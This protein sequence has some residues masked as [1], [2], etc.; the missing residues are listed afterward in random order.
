MR[1]VVEHQIVENCNAVGTRIRLGVEREVGCVPVIGNEK[2]DV[3][4]AL[5]EMALDRHLVRRHHEDAGS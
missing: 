1:A 2:V 3:V 4:I 5:H